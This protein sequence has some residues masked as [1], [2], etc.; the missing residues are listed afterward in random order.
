MI[1]ILGKVVKNNKIIKE[2][3]EEFDDNKNYQENLKACI[4]KICHELDISKPYWL[5]SNLDEYNNRSKLA[6]DENNF[7]EDINFDKFII[8]ELNIDK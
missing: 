8:E 1:K 4:T 6:F 5:P 2:H 7:I 3:I